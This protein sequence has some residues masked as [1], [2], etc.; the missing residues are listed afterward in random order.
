MESET[1][2]LEPTALV[3]ETF[4]RLS[5]L[6]NCVVLTAPLRSETTKPSA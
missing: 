1:S 4:L 3:N 6:L 5:N 2:T